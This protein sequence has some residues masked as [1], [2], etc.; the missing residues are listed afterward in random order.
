MGIVPYDYEDT[1][2]ERS[3]FRTI[4]DSFMKMGIKSAY[5]D[6]FCNRYENAAVAA[7]SLTQAVNRYGYPIRVKRRGTDIWIIRRD[8]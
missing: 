7:S 5:L 8:I 6:G 4:L 2:K 1:P 3:D